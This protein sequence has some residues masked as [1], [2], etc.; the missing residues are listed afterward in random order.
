[1]K[2]EGFQPTKSSKLCSEHFLSSDFIF[3]FGKK[4]LKPD[5]IPT[6]FNFPKHLIKKE[7]KP[8]SLRL[9]RTAVVKSP[10]IDPVL[11]RYV[12][13]IIIIAFI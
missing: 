11:P 9:N 8:R 6:V 12:H 5:V 2:R 7:V 1:M 4:S 3:N 10:D 13:Y